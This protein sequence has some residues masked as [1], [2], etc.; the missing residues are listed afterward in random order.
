MEKE[1]ITKEK[2]KEIMLELLNAIDIIC[3]K[4][5]IRYYLCGGTLLGAIRHKGF[6]P[7]DDDIDILLFRYDYE[8]LKAILKKQTLF[9]HFS[10]LDNNIEG[11]VYPFMKFVDNRT[12][13]RQK[14]LKVKHGIWVDIFPYD[15]VPD[16]PFK[17]YCFLKLCQI[18]RAIILST[19]TDFSGID[20]LSIKGFA[21]MIL[22]LVGK[23]IG[24][25]NMARITERHMVKYNN[26]QCGCVCCNFSPYVMREYIP[27][28]VIHE[29]TRVIFEGRKYYSFKNWDTYLSKL[30]GNYMQIPPKDKQKTHSIKAWWL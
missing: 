11:Y 29:Y 2:S 9:P 15:S 1:F 23:I 6:I 16:S 24:I 22:F 28:E 18:N 25:K 13:A 8:K 14:D 20:K 4:N 27:Y 26:T 7:W 17:R 10:V 21:R 5:S 12:V 3:E 19:V 30:Y